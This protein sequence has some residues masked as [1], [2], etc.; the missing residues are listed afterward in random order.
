VRYHFAVTD[1]PKR[2]VRIASDDEPPY[3]RYAFLNPYNLSLL[4]GAAT[5]AAA[6]GHWWIAVCAAAT[7]GLWMLFA[8][9]SKVLQSTL[10]R[11][12]W[13]HAQR[14]RVEERRRKKFAL[15]TPV[16]QARAAALSDQRMRILQ[17]ATENPSLTAEL[18]KAELD[19]L[20]A[21]LEDFLDLAAVC[22]R[23]ERQLGAFDAVG[24]QRSSQSYEDQVRRYAPTDKRREVAEK[25]LEVLK[26]RRN[27]VEAMQ[28]NL[29][30]ARGHMDLMENSFR[31]LSDEIVTMADPTELAAR[32]DD[33]RIGVQAIR[34]TTQGDEDALY[35]EPPTRQ[36]R[37]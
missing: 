19:K 35:E 30:T 33:L 31:L 7:E 23:C 29:Q 32:L 12:R 5:T 27:R 11:K 17:L 22:A 4:A 37:G 16:D 13:E 15:L 3:V 34:E 28:R 21:L 6:T 2:K 20:D 18:M 8:P 10:W 1:E 36:A 26:Q 24:W 9:G 14:D 25:N